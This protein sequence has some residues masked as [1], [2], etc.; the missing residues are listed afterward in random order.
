MG[1]DLIILLAAPAIIGISYWLAKNAARASSSTEISFENAI[2]AIRVPKENEKDAL[3]AEQM[4]SSLHGLLRL[5]PGIQEHITFEIAASSSGINFYA[6]CPRALRAFVESQVYAQYPAA[7][8]KEIPDYASRSSAFFDRA[9][10]GTVL[11]LARPEYF[12]I[13]TFREFEVDPLAAITSAISQM[14]ENE[15]IWIQILLRPVPDV[16]QRAGHNYVSAV[17]TGTK[18]VEFSF[19]GIFQAII[20]EVAHLPAHMFEGVAHPAHKHAMEYKAPV[21]KDKPDIS[22]GMEEE[23]KAI[24]FKLAKMGFQ[25]LVR[26]VAVA[27]TPEEAFSH[28]RSV[29]ASFRQFSTANLNSFVPGDTINNKMEFLESYRRR[30]LPEDEVYV[31]GTEEL[32]SVFHLPSISVET[33]LIDWSPA[34]RGE[35]PL[36]LPTKDCTYIGRTTFRDSMVRFGLKRDDRTTHFY[37]VGKTG[38]GKTTLFKNMI[39]QDIRNGEGVGVIDP[40]GDLIEELLDFIPEN[41]LEDVVLFDPGD[42]AH[43]VGLNVLECPDP[44][45]KNLM[46][47]GLVGAVRNH[48]EN[49]WGP[50][51]EY[52]LNNAVLTLLEVP[53]TTMLG[54]TRVLEDKNYQ[55]YIVHKIKDPILKDF[56]E[57]E[58]KQMMSNVAFHTEAIAPIQNKIGRFLASSTIRNILGQA[59]STLKIDDIMNNRKIL[60]ANLAKGKIGADNANLLGS[61]LV[62]RINFMAMQRVKLPPEQRADFYLYVDEFQ[63][64]ASGAFSSILSEARKYRLSLHM[65]HQYTAQLPEEVSEAVFGNVGTMVV[66]G[67]GAP[68]A[69]VLAP[70]FAPYF[71]ENDLISL[72]R[73]HAYVK[74]MINGMTEAPFSAV[75]DPPPSDPAGF[76]EEVRNKSWAKYSTDSKLVEDRIGRWTERQ[77]DLGM[78][79]AEETKAKETAASEMEGVEEGEEVKESPA[80]VLEEVPPV[81]VPPK[82]VE[83]VAPHHSEPSFL[84]REIGVRAEPEKTVEVEEPQSPVKTPHEV[85]LP[86]YQKFNPLARESEIT[87]PIKIENYD[88]HARYTHSR[89]GKIIEPKIKKEGGDQK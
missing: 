57:N 17:R 61:L 67:V 54:I 25:V 20:D 6:V 88:L 56:W 43:P 39:V 85:P 77:F 12:P 44:A 84:V 53:S 36:N 52:L 62:S 76:R 74:M 2:L 38:A 58:F 42:T 13:R 71:E 47:S 29:T 87:S 30:S 31:L 66:F 86:P 1:F 34:K 40:H 64:F 48:F 81:V 18:P 41:R 37:S 79:I 28:L 49:S 73:H 89:H 23:L 78:A 15:E 33:P 9:V 16:W 60:L 4:F 80:P 63:N 75:T 26:L 7:E 55:K 59:R 65:T 70:E 51:L 35:P 14:K 68:D 22:K 21:R 10:E 8:I 5:T 82:V 3:A 27:P 24:E 32:A 45:Q 46:A 11:K 83:A 19:G 50:R 69:H 72:E